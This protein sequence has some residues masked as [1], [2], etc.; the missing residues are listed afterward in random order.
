MNTQSNQKQCRTALKQ[1]LLKNASF[2]VWIK[3]EAK[4]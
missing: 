2:E 3:E 1:G 4:S